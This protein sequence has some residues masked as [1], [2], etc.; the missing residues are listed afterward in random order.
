MQM[1]FQ[2]LTPIT[3]DPRQLSR[4]SD[5]LRIGRQI[6][7]IFVHST[8]SKPAHLWVPEALSLRVKRP[9]READLSPPSDT[10]IKT[11]GTIKH[12]YIDISIYFFSMLLHQAA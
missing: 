1:K 5:G 6:Y 4:Y 10:E 8:M 2:T 11:G 3:D 7:E 9:G 12:G